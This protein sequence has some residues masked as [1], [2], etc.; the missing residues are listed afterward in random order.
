MN[1]Q[2]YHNAR[3]EFFLPAV[4]PGYAAGDR[5]Y[6]ARGV[7]LMTVV[8]SEFLIHPMDGDRFRPL[9]ALPFLQMIFPRPSSVEAE[10]STIFRIGPQPIHFESMVEDG[11][12]L[13]FEDTDDHL[14]KSKV[15]SFSHWENW[16][17]S[18]D[19]SPTNSPEE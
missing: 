17:E 3:L 12:H 13:V 15:D 4:N 10:E 5:V 8:G 14:S 19:A 16:S 1:L 11:L 6:L 2:K 18:N 7:A 9:S